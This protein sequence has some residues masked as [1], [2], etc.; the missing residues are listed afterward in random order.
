M[1]PESLRKFDLFYIAAIGIGLASGLLNYDAQMRMLESQMA[2]SGLEQYSGGIVLA[3]A[4][5]AL[6]FNLILW[7]LASRLRM[8]WV[9]WVIV[10]LVLYS[11]GTLV[12]GL[13]M[14][15]VSVSITGLITVLLKAI[16]VSFL[17]RPDAKAWFAGG[18]G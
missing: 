16:A 14:S 18:A 7:L 1:R 17:F 6:A 10:A 5:I 11:L 9:K 12:V 15:M 2:G 8:G 4:G 13:S 3:S